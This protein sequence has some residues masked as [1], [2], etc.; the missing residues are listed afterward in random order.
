MRNS[1]GMLLLMLLVST[2]GSVSAFGYLD[3]NGNGTGLPGYSALSVGF[4]GAKA[5]GF[6]DALSVLTNPADIYRIP[7]TS[8]SL[9]VGPGVIREMVE[10]SLGKHDRTWLTLGNLS[11]AVKFQV[12]PSLAVAAGVAAVSDF[13]YDGLHYTYD[14]DPGPEYGQITEER[15]LRVTGGLWESA[16]GFAW[17]PATWINV[18]LSAGL[19]F[20]TVSYD[21]TFKDRREPENDNEIK[22]TID[23]SEA[24]WH[25]GIAIPMNLARIGLCYTSGGEHY[26]ASLAAGALLYTDDARQAAFGAEA[27]ITDPGDTNALT[28]RILGQFLPSPNF[29]VRGCFFF[30]DRADEVDREGLGLAVGT[31]IGLGKVSLNGGFSWSSVDRSALAFGYEAPEDIKDSASLVSFGVTWNP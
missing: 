21:S 30:M 20:G 14:T 12:S 11:G 6:G 19:R 1:T 3:A 17:R 18:G 8:V 13:S 26:D 16:A 5:V 28:V 31:T 27:E 9:S 15:S 22:W 24:A 7:G 4:G 25:A 10:D 2:V 29:A 23:E